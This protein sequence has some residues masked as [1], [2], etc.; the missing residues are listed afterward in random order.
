MNANIAYVPTWTDF[1]T[2]FKVV[3][4]ASPF[5]CRPLILPITMPKGKGKGKRSSSFDAT[6][7][8]NGVHCHTNGVGHNGVGSKKTKLENGA[9]G[10]NGAN[11]HQVSDYSI[12]PTL[13]APEMVSTDF[14]IEGIVGAFIS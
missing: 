13:T 9:N 14:E 3:L 10:S 2:L 6:E 8:T 11:G 1:Y 7:V 5:Q 4:L 12:N